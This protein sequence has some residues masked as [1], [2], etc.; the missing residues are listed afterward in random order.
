MGGVRGGAG[1]GCLSEYGARGVHGQCG[2]GDGAAGGRAIRREHG[3]V[4]GGRGG[5]FEERSELENA[6]NGRKTCKR[7]SNGTRTRIRD[8]AHIN[9][10]SG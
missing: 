1:K 10:N 6:V 5:L 4:C 3:V 7:D 9:S 8:H 2:L